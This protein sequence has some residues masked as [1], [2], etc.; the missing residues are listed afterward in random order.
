MLLHWIVIHSIFIILKR[1]FTETNDS[2]FKNPC[3]KID[4]YAL[5]GFVID[6]SKKSLHLYK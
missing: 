1:F 2:Q 4:A 3:F 6:A 5:A